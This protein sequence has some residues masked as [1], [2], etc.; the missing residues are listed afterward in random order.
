MWLMFLPLFHN[1]D[2]RLEEAAATSGAGRLQTLLRVTVPLMVFAT[3]MLVPSKATPAG[4]PSTVN[5]P[6]F[7]ASEARSFVRVL[8]DQL[9][10]QMLAPSKASA[11]GS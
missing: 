7:R 6:R 8:V 11:L 1:A 2:P 3:Q 9:E 4:P 5:V 10:T